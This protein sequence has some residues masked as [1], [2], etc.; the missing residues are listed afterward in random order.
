MARG[1]RCSGAISMS[2]DT[3]TPAPE[4]ESKV[5]LHPALGYA[6][7]DADSHYY[8]STDALTRHL[9]PEMS[10]RGPR[11]ATVNGRERLLLGDKLYGYIPNPTFDPVAK[12]GCL[13][14][15]FA[16]K[17]GGKDM[18]EQMGELEPVRPEYRDRDVR[19]KVMD[20]QGVGATW[21]FPTLAVT[22]EVFMQPDIPAAL[23]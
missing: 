6:A 8:E 23:A 17:V 18:I 4:G 21:L 12:P 9:A 14:D 2:V 13:H 10:R 11:W 22:L 1:T 5:R 15:Y 19:L 3:A 16:G 20:E 7:F